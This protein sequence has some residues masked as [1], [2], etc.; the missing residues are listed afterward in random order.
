MQSTTLLLLGLHRARNHSKLL[1]EGEIRRW[2]DE[3]SIGEESADDP[4]SDLLDDPEL[5]DY[6]D[7]VAVVNCVLTSE[8]RTVQQLIDDQL[9]EDEED[10]DSDT[11]EA[12]VPR[13]SSVGATLDAFHTIR[14]F[15]YTCENAE[16]ELSQLNR[17]ENFVLR[18]APKR[19][20]KL[21]K[22]F[23]PPQ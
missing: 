6:A 8:V 19:Q 10:D 5:A 4:D 11:D 15:I 13:A 14:N 2:G 21:D 1:P 20:A 23:H 9:C 22:F 16:S 12:P 7:Y 18:H 3:T 17:L